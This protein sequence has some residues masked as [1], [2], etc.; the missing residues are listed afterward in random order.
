MGI[1]SGITSGA[2]GKF[3]RRVNLWR[4]GG[5][6]RRRSSVTLWAV[7]WLGMAAASARGQPL[8][9]V[10]PNAGDSGEFGA[11]VSGVA[12]LNGDGRGE[13]LVGA[14]SD[15]PGGT[16]NAGRAYI[17][18]G[19]DGTALRPLVSPNAQES[20][21]FGM[22]VSAASDVNGDGWEDVVVGAPWE[23]AGGTPGA[24]RAYI[25]S[26]SDGTV[27]W[28]L[29]SPNRQDSG[30]FGM[31]VS[32]VPD[33]NADGRGDVAVGAYNED[34]GVGPDIY[35]R[36]YIFSGS[37]GM[38][39]STL[40]L[41]SWESGTVGACVSG[42]ADVNGDGRGDVVSGGGA[43]M[44]C[45]G[46]AHIFS[47]S[48]GTLLHA[49]VSPVVDPALCFGISVS[50]IPDVNGD[51]RGDVIVG[52]GDPNFMDG[53]TPGK[54]YIFSGSDGT[55]LTPLS[56]PVFWDEGDFGAAVTGIPDVNGDGRGDAI[57]GGR[58]SFAACVF[59]GLDGT[60]LDTLLSPDQV[61]LTLFGVASSGIPDVNGDGGLDFVVGAPGVP[62]GGRA[63]I[64]FGPTPIATPTK[65][66][67]VMDTPTPPATPTATQTPQPWEHCDV[68]RDGKVDH[69][70]I[71][72]IQHWW[73]EPDR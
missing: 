57:V 54:A 29:V 48:D 73:H 12:D 19:S 42:V 23:L 65:T 11:S 40:V 39:I 34:P 15:N 46:G 7:A 27:L 26:G 45:V 4:E 63:Y 35:G 55:V 8:E 17:F 10:S 24:G 66:P 72:E 43:T 9:L 25:I 49:L 38:L 1:A 60:V 50:G 68:N 31:S 58:F 33:V 5:G 52:A 61:N 59:S 3:G 64:F 69:L 56:P 20:G 22:S 36:A 44:S 6:V 47:G 62:G 71:I 14:P 18:L 28:P 67:T 37:D 2:I 32:G 41:P 13:V 16:V 21:G 53:I 51:G 30:Q 70:D